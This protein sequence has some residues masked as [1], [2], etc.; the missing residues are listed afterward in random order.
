MSPELPEAL[1]VALRVIDVLDELRVRYHVGGSYASSIHGIPRQTQDI[2]LVVELPPEGA[3]PLA[4]KLGDEFYVDEESV[5]RAARDK[6]SANVIH[7]DSGIKIDLFV[8]GD[9]PF[10]LEEFRRHRR[11]MIRREPE[12]Y[13]YVKTAEDTLL[14]KL[15]WYRMGGETSDRQWNDVLGIARTQGETLDREYVERWAREL[16][17]EDLLERVLA[18]S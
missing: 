1:R 9:S 11:E 16:G 13:V 7:L 18:E 17:V 14:R 2:D 8:L 4:S 3:G 12:R 10:D 15:L 5:R 6:T